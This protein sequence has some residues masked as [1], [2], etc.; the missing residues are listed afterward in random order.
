MLA[1]QGVGN[2]DDQETYLKTIETICEDTTFPLHVRSA[3]EFFDEY[4]EPFWGFARN[5]EDLHFMQ[6]SY[7]YLFEQWRAMQ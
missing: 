7:D 6:H 5:D 4:M 1:Q 3:E 2:K